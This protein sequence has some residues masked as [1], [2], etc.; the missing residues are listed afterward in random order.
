MPLI[1]QVEIEFEKKEKREKKEREVAAKEANEKLHSEI[2]AWDVKYMPEDKLSTVSFSA[3][4]SPRRCLSPQSTAIHRL[5]S[6]CC[7]CGRRSGR[8]GRCRA[9]ASSST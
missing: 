3:F 8:C 7:C 2:E 9:W 5:S 1:K 6:W 4:R